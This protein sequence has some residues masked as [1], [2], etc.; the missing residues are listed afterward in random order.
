VE[1]ANVDNMGLIEGIVVNG[2]SPTTMYLVFRTETN[3]TE[4]KVM[5]GSVGLTES[6]GN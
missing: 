6:V 3:G 5:A 2:A 4:V 1:I